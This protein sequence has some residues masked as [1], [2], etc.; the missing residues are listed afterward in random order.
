[1]AVSLQV[2]SNYANDYADGIRGTDIN[3]LGPDRLVAA[4]RATPS[5]VKRAAYI[6]FGVGAALGLYIVILSAQWWLLAVG[7]LAIVAAWTYTASERPYGY[8]GWGEVSVLFFF[9]P[10]AVLGTMLTQAETVTWWALVASI[11][12]GLWAVALLMINNIRDIEGDALAGK[13]TLAV[14]LGAR[15]A[16]SL[17]GVT[18]LSTL[19]LAV[20]IAFEHPWVLLTFLTATPIVFFAVAMRLGPQGLALR[21]FF[22]GVSL[23]GFAYGLLLALGLAL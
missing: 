23:V 8:A 15:R 7:A 14:Q 1:V 3:R 10:V 22:S 4:G 11:A 16:R 12:V 9:G 21:P 19:A 17:F 20:V 13:R 2:A 6:A 5:A 18:I